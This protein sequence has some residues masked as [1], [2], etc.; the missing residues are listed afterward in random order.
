MQAKKG[1]RIGV[2]I[3]GTF[4]DVVAQLPDGRVEIRKVSSD[5]KQPAD[6]VISGL[7]DL[8]AE[9][10]L[11]PGLITEIIHGTT[12]GSNTL[13]QKSGVATGLMTTKGFRD[14]L[15]IAR[16]RT[17]TMFDLTWSKPEPLV[18]RRHRVE[19]DER[20]AADGSVL[21]P[22]RVEDIEQRADFLAAEGVRSVAICFINSYANPDHEREAAEVLRLRQPDLMVTASVDVL[23]EVKEYERTSTTVVN[24]YLLDSMRRY[25]SALSERLASLG[26]DAPLQVVASSGGTM[27]METASEKPV[28]AVASGPAGGVIG[29]A[30]LGE[31]IHYADAIVFDMGGTTA[32]A[33]IVEAGLPSLTTEY[34]F[35]DGISSP[36]RFVK[37]GGYMLKVPSIDI[38]EVGAGGGSIAWID[39]GGLLQIGPESAG[40]LPG[41]ACYDKGNARPTVTDANV[42]LGML[43]PGGL[44][45]GSLGIK[46]ALAC[47]AIRTY[48]G[49]PLGLSV[50][51]AA[52]GIRRIANV[53]MARAIRSVTI[54]RGKD[55]RDMALMA[56]GGGGPVHAVD[57][58][59]ILN[60]STVIVPPA[61]GVFA[62]LGMLT[63][64]VEHALVRSLTRRLDSVDASIL[65]TVYAELGDEARSRLE[66]DGFVGTEVSVDYALDLRYLGQ[67]SEI[68]VAVEP[69]VDVVE[70]A[71]LF[72]AAYR[73]TFGYASDDAVELVNVRVTGRGR[74]PHR[75]QFD[76]VKLASTDSGGCTSRDVYFEAEQ[77]METKC[78]PRNSVTDKALA[79][80]LILEAYDTTVVL[81]KGAS[82]RRGLCDTLVID[83]ADTLFE[84]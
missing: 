20:I 33:A 77:A 44:A 78:V 2:D 65:G 81:P 36:S 74:H 56:F 61:S 52:L 57:V 69:K 68:T 82:V 38:A 48:I 62:S 47:E 35:R 1:V 42:V 73:E 41:P 45:G 49:E 16:I 6:A 21:R 66:R 64:D 24:A 79:G 32:K 67:S 27:R 12:V 19:I 71:R 5:P 46:P 26:I 75:L 37:G 59:A 72:Y 3:G 60:L 51:E 55:P 83:V 28:F 34:E 14:V 63:S 30:R 58:A 43:N 22:L 76:Q 15:E 39:A 23:P 11:E 4:T 25:L 17:P 29:A 80:P 8:L 50:I 84:R 18:P 54:E 40:S 10:S 9:L 70:L 31:A 7:T 13:L 53:S